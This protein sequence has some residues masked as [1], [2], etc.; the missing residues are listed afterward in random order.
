MYIVHI[1][2][3]LCVCVPVH[4]YRYVYAQYMNRGEKIISCV[5]PHLPPSMK[6][7][8]PCMPS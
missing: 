2:S 5:G 4:K 7:F 8:S 3:Y 1:Y 6:Q